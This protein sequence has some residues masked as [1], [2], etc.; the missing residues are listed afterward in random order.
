MVEC[1]ASS[2]ALRGVDRRTLVDLTRFVDRLLAS[3][4]MLL[5]DEFPLEVERRQVT[6]R[7]VPSMRVLQE[8]ERG[9]PRLGPRLER[10]LAEQFLLE[11]REECLGPGGVDGIA[12]RASLCTQFQRSPC[13]VALS[14]TC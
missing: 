12:D 2:W 14:S 10:P 8:A 1:R 7:R 13:S 5:S 4:S 9:S 3:R 11:R 6:E